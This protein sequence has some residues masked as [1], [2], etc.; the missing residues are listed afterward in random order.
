MVLFILLIRSINT[1]VYQNK[2]MAHM[3]FAHNNAMIRAAY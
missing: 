3:P 1:L 2:A